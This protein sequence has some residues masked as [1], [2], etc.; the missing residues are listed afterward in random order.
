MRSNGYET[1][2]PLDGHC[3]GLKKKNKGMMMVRL[4]E[5]MRLTS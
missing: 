4:M 3:E 2:D 5:E 1:Y